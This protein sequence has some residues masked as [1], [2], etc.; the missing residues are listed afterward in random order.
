[1]RG[2]YKQAHQKKLASFQQQ[3]CKFRKKKTNKRKKL[4]PKSQYGMTN[5]YAKTEKQ[6]QKIKQ[7]GIKVRNK[8]TN[9]QIN[10]IIDPKSKQLEAK[11]ITN[12]QTNNQSI[13]KNKKRRKKENNNNK[14]KNKEDNSY[15]SHL[16]IQL[17]KQQ[18]NQTIAHQVAKK[19]ITAQENKQ[20]NKL[21]KKRKKK[22]Q[23]K[24]KTSQSHPLKGKKRKTSTKSR[25]QLQQATTTKQ[26][27]QMEDQ[28]YYLQHPQQ[29]SQQGSA[30]QGASSAN[31]QST[32]M[33]GYP[34]SHQ[35]QHI[36]Y[37]NPHAPYP[38]HMT[39]PID[40][41]VHPS[42][43]PPTG[44]YHPSAS[45]HYPGQLHHGYSHPS[46]P[47]MQQTYSQG[48]YDY[49]PTGQIGGLYYGTPSTVPLSS[50][51]TGQIGSNGQPLQG[52]G[53]YA[54]YPGQLPPPGHYQ[55]NLGLDPNAQQ[56]YGQ[57]HPHHSA[58]HHPGAAFGTAPG[59]PIDQNYMAF[60]QQSQYHG[61]PGNG[62]MPFGQPLPNG[63]LHHHNPYG[64]IQNQNQIGI[65]DSSN[66]TRPPQS[67]IGKASIKNEEQAMENELQL[68]NSLGDSQSQQEDK[69]KQGGSNYLIPS[70]YD[71]Q[72]PYPYYLS[73]QSYGIQKKDDL[74]GQN[75]YFQGYP[76]YPTGQ[77]PP[78]SQQSIPSLQNAASSTS[79]KDKEDPSKRQPNSP[80]RR[81]T[82]KKGSPTGNTEP[83]SPASPRGRKRK[84]TAKLDQPQPESTQNLNQGL[85][86]QQQQQQFGLHLVKVSNQD[87]QKNM[88]Y[89]GQ[90]Y[91]QPVNA[92]GKVM[93]DPNTQHISGIDQNS[94]QRL[95]ELPT[96]F[97]MNEFTAVYD[98]QKQI[99]SISKEERKQKIK[100]Y[101]D[102]RKRRSWQKK[103]SYD[104]RKKVADGRL[105]VKGRFVTK[106]QAME[107]LS[108]N[109]KEEDYTMDQLKEMLKQQ[110]I[111]A[112]GGE[113]DSKS[114]TLP[115]KKNQSQPG[116][117][118]SLKPGD[119]DEEEGYGSGGEVHS[120][121][122]PPSEVLPII[123]GKSCEDIPNKE[124]YFQGQGEFNYQNIVQGSLASNNTSNNNSLNEKQLHLKLEQNQI[125]SKQQL[126]Q[127]QQLQNQQSYSS[128]TQSQSQSPVRSPKKQNGGFQSNNTV[129]FMEQNQGH[130]IQNVNQIE[131]SNNNNIK[132]VN[133]HSSYADL[134]NG[135]SPQHSQNNILSQEMADQFGNLNIKSP[136]QKQKIMQQKNNP[137]LL[138]LNQTEQ[139][140]FGNNQASQN[141][142][143]YNQQQ[144]NGNNTGY[145]IHQQQ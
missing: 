7:E 30:T 45:S 43:P 88:G 77:Y 67:S 47:Y 35:M 56:P 113:E 98:D 138:N 111:Q 50:D 94:L 17:I 13:K 32:G 62:Y 112:N 72:P 68:I 133:G 55:Q 53:P 64:L 137:Q 21:T 78:G 124:D 110:G 46:D 27:Q 11:E 118:V 12:K 95:K 132:N 79:I 42:N 18:I 14:V 83:S 73:N 92:L 126:Q 139:Q 65:I 130:Q 135:E 74:M 8:Q 102:K 114:P 23:H 116:T 57:Y 41:S 16:I 48:P 128:K 15:L 84:N 19:E 36:P 105:R 60:G 101:Q 81:K 121:E 134:Q 91:Y 38:N 89:P 28:A 145:P 80:G 5:R 44:P 9:Q 59:Q 66:Q 31:Y 136:D 144:Y 93:I 117:I 87:Q 97:N 37:Q 123:R 100:N 3:L 70:Q 125:E 49:D 52:P 33:A 115:K 82:I 4:N 39:G 96:D 120:E 75:Q 119:D 76:Q 141:Y 86:N 69:I 142:N 20:T 58:H 34:Q 129:K 106:K 10:K 127:F 40:Y 71:Q 29:T 104:V 99:G 140:F 51:P 85:I 61:P 22:K 131:N 109:G 108:I 122:L 143:L 54:T 107:M 90:P 26:M 2:M 6:Q 63:Q 24:R 103:I 1:M 25:R